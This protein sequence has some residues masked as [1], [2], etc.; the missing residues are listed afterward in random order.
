[1]FM[2]NLSVLTPDEI[3]RRTICDK[4]Y[5][6]KLSYSDLFFIRRGEYWETHPEMKV[7]FD[8]KYE[9]HKNE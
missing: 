5:K 4:L 1:M 7:A 6:K 8:R 3:D 9:E 2:S